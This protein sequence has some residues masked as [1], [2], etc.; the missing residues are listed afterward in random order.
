MK[1]TFLCAAA[2]VMA[3]ALVAAPPAAKAD[4]VN[5]VDFTGPAQDFSAVVTATGTVVGSGTGLL[6]G[7]PF[8]LD[9]NPQTLPVGLSPDS[10]TV[11]S[12][13]K[14][15]PP[16]A[17]F[18]TDAACDLTDI[19]D[20][21]LDILNGNTAVVAL[22]PILIT[23]KIAG[24]IP[25]T[26]DINFTG[27]VKSIR[28][29][30]TGAPTINP[31]LDE[32]LVPGDITAVFGGNAAILAGAVS[33]PIPDTTIT[34]PI[35]LPGTY[36]MT[37]VSGVTHNMELDGDFDLDLPLSLVTV[38]A[39]SLGAALGFTG[40]IDLQASVQFAMSYHLEDLVV[41]VP[42]P[43]SVALFGIGLVALIPVVRRRLK[44]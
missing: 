10:I 31:G 40:T 4:T 2:I 23:I 8:A 37:P 18:S 44:K 30:Q 43:G 7:T 22:D 6:F 9:P 34:T 13:P 33:L 14:S 36:T 21:D 27:T 38:L 1:H 25:G 28:F 19:Q 29:D 5:L 20:L 32:Y 12:D 17:S 15:D 11:T 39:T 16:P 3:I 26:I 24:I 41:C 42:E 35:V